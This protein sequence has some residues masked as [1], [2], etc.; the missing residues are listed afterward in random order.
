MSF[1][2]RYAILLDGGFVIKKLESAAKRFPSA[3]D[4]ELLCRNLQRRPELSQAELLRIYFYHARPAKDILTN[5]IDKSL[6]NLGA[7]KIYAK[8]ERLL[9]TLE[10]KPDFAIRL[11]ETVT[12]EWRL[13]SSAMKSLMK[14]ARPVQPSD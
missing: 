9:N 8:H 4:I 7:T 13:G 2:A 11:G 1:A 5:P 14:V 12:H 6:L 3:D 10:L